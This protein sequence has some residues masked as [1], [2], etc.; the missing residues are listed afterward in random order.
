MREE[1][2]EHTRLKLLNSIHKDKEDDIN[3]YSKEYKVDFATMTDVE[4]MNNI[5]YIIHTHNL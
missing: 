4:F 5:Q 3:V 1:T 2:I